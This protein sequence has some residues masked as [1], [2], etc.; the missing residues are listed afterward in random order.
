MAESA[1]RKAVKPGWQSTE[2]WLSAGATIWP[3]LSD[4]IP[5]TWKAAILTAS[6]GIYT[7]AR[8]IVKRGGK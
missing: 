6:A 7:I 8:A 2:F 4:A 3:L 5:P 1:E